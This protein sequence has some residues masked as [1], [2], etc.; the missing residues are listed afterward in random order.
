MPPRRRR[1]VLRAPRAATCRWG[2][3]YKVWAYVSAMRV[4]LSLYAGGAKPLCCY[5]QVGV[6]IQSVGGR[7]HRTKTITLTP[8][9]IIVN[10]LGVALD[11]R[12]EGTAHAVAIPGAADPCSSSSSSSG[13]LVD[14][15]Q[16]NKLVWHWT[17]AR[18][19]C[20]IKALSFWCMRP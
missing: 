1:R 17:D 8:R 11:V 15:P 9:Y 4:G 18:K 7:F 3:R 19:R 2:W 16:S 20:D 12:Q 14:D 6:A 13:A 5:M 10:N